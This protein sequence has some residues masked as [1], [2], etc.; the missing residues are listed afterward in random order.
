MRSNRFFI[1]LGMLCAL[2]AHASYWTT[3]EDLPDWLH[4]GNLR[5]VQAG[6]SNMEQAQSLVNQGFN[7]LWGGYGTEDPKLID[8]L[9][10]N[11]VHRT[12]YLCSTSLFWNPNDKENLFAQFPPML[13]GTV[14]ER[15]GTRKVIYA[16]PW[17]RD[18]ATRRFAG[19]RLS[20]QYLEYQQRRM[21][22]FARGGQPF[23]DDPVYKAMQS[24]PV[25]PLHVYFLD[26]PFMLKCYCPVCQDAWAAYCQKRFGTVV[27]DPE[28]CG[29]ERIRNAWDFFWLDANAKYINN[30]KQYAN[31]MPEK[32]FIAP[33]WIHGY[34]EYYY[35]MEHSDADVVL[36]ELGGGGE[37]P[38]GR[39]E[40]SYKVAS[41]ATDGKAL[42]NI[43]CF[44]A[45]RPRLDLRRPALP[46]IGGERAPQASYLTCA[47]AAANLSSY[48]STGPAQFNKFLKQ[49]RHL[50]GDAQPASSVALVYSTN[51][52]LW[53]RRVYHVDGTKFLGPDWWIGMDYTPTAH[54]KHFAD[55]L[56]EQGVPYD[57][58]VDR[59]FTPEQL[60]SYKCVIL[61]DVQ[62]VTPEGARALRQFAS[63]GGTVL[64]SE[65]FSLRDFEGNLLSRGDALRQGGALAT[66]NRLTVIRPDQLTLENF[67][68]DGGDG[69]IAVLPSRVGKG[70]PNTAS[71][72]LQ[73][74]QIP[75]G[76]GPFLVKVSCFD[77]SLGSG[78][79]SLNLNGIRQAT[80]KLD[81]QSDEFRPLTVKL[82]KLKAGDVL[83]LKAD[84]DAGELCWIEE[85]RIQAPQ[86]MVRTGNGFVLFEP[87]PL[88]SLD[89]VHLL[90]LLTDARAFDIRLTPAS[91]RDDVFINVLR[92]AKSGALTMH[93]L[94]STTNDMHQATI[95]DHSACAARKQLALT[96][97]QRNTLTKPV[98][99]LLGFTPYWTQT[100]LAREVLKQPYLH[101]EQT[102]A[103]VT[104]SVNGTEVG[105]L[106]LGK[107][108]D[109]WTDVPVDPQLL[110]DNNTVEVRVAGDVG[111]ARSYYGLLIDPGSE[112]RDSHW[113]P[114]PW[115]EHN[116]ASPDDLSPYAGDQRGSYM[117]Y[118]RNAGDKAGVPEYNLAHQAI[119]GPTVTLPAAGFEKPAAAFLTPDGETQA[120][121]VPLEVKRNGKMLSIQLPKID[122]Y[123]VVVL[124]GSE[125]ELQAL[126]A[127]K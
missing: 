4:R 73:R 17:D 112:A 45:A 36:V 117:I 81:H 102:K 72:R 74:E 60:A 3:H 97:E 39:S 54:V 85:I 21:E 28:T 50:Y 113:T 101:K 41:A 104:V 83:T 69:R 108:A 19:C 22:L 75:E 35:M 1:I 118:L 26:N 6:A 37:R 52:E 12:V 77:S 99:S 109:D 27:A 116:L 70:I 49:Y 29:D 62:C 92:P 98:V 8:F 65:N 64:V 13:Q 90:R 120:P 80:L 2:S 126:L 55:R 125:E 100:Y 63:N 47:E 7:L 86:Q 20:P 106:P 88:N 121:P 31:N 122:V 9:T 110:K 33:N 82:N 58:L 96:T 18:G 115:V 123:G 105:R 127:G 51:T 87:E 103:W 11:G 89:D 78:A 71:L 53:R 48:L 16:N 91:P 5:W 119:D 95:L 57:V 40:F 107:M 14:L 34:P 94:N 38:W 30:L 124:A 56:T 44:P 79:V 67:A 66:A 76:E 15:D 23:P 24:G 61:P 84:P 111:F 114:G 43:W 10:G 32:R 46:F 93:V 42:V 25:P 59:Q 68:A